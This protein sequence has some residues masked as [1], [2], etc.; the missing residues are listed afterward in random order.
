MRRVVITGV[1]AV[2][3]VGND[4]DSTW[5]SIRDSV[6]GI[7]PI[8]LFDTEDFP[9]RYAA[10]VKDYVPSEHFRPLD[11]KKLSRAAQFG[12]IASQEAFS[13]SGLEGSGYDSSRF[14]VF[15]GSGAGGGIPAEEYAALSEKGADGISKLMIPRGLINMI[16]ANVAIRL[17]AHGSCLPVV[18]A[19]STGTDCIG[20]AYRD[21]LHGYSDI[22]AA[23]GAEAGISSIGLAG[24]NAIGALAK[25][26]DPGR[27]SIPFDLE[28]T[29]FVM[30]EGAGC[31][32]LE[33]MEH[34]R[35]RNAHIYAE[36]TG[37]GSSC[38]AY[39]LTAPDPSMKHGSRAMLAALAEAGAAP[40]DISYINAHGTGT[41][42]N[43]SY[44][45]AMIKN[46]FGEYSRSIPVSSTK[47][48]TGH[49]LGASGAV[50]T[51]IICKAMENGIVP[52]TAGYSVS[53]PLCDL[54]YVTDGARQAEIRYAMNNSL[55]FGGHN[56]VLIL[57][58]TDLKG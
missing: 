49:L 5:S 4:A 48:M 35:K 34:A 58:N 27:L 47:S 37:Y 10:E 25:G 11:L 53:D 39:N 30:G 38:D 14:S 24:F 32:I 23:G 56:A 33:E 28:R 44:E 7:A 2:S 13:D 52:P 18:T 8:T 22:S 45:T 55:G 54:D 12:I 9:I 29:G 15:F 46:V 51:V 36:I 16:A 57:K 26:G 3:P 42:L 19:C 1:G 17:G 6:C 50:E 31:L 40:E 21:I 41:K 20:M 43:D